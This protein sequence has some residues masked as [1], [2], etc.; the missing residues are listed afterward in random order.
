[1][2]VHSADYACSNF[3]TFFRYTCSKHMLRVADMRCRMRT[4]RLI[5]QSLMDSERRQT[6]CTSENVEEQEARLDSP[7]R[8]N[9]DHSPSIL[10]AVTI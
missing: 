5:V 3:A 6:L 4:C 7:V 9:A 1:M 2:L 8:Q 10:S